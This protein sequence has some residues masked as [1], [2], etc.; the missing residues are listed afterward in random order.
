MMAGDKEFNLRHVDFKLLMA[1]SDRGDQKVL[2]HTKRE[3]CNAQVLGELETTP[4][5]ESVRPLEVVFPLRHRR[6]TCADV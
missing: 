3:I 5:V 2:C 6:S 1:H 4:D